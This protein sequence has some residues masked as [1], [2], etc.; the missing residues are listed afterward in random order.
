MATDVLALPVRVSRMGE[1]NENDERFI[2]ERD[3]IDRGTQ[4]AE[5]AGYVVRVYDDK[6]VSGATPFDQRPGMGEALRDL[7]AGRIAG[8]VTAYRDRLVRQDPE[9]NVT[10]AA[11]QRRIRDADGVLIVGDTPAA[12]IGPD[13]DV[14]EGFAG[15]GLD[16]LVALDGRYREEARKR[17]DT[18]NRYAVERGVQPGRTPKWMRRDEDGYLHPNEHT[19]AVVEAV[20]ARAG[21][22]SWAE[23]AELLN[24]RG[25]PTSKGGPW[26]YKTAS[27][28]L[29]S[30]LLVGRVHWGPHRNDA[31]FEPLVDE[32]TW[33]LANRRAD[34]VPRTRAPGLATGIARCAECGKPMIQDSSKRRDGGRTATYRCR[35]GVCDRP[36]T[37]TH[38]LLEPYLWD[39]AWAESDR[40][41]QAEIREGATTAEDGGP[42]PDELRV[43]LRVAEEEIAA[44]LLNVRPT[45]PGYAD[46]LRN[47]EDEMEAARER[48]AES[49]APRE[50]TFREVVEEGYRNL[51]DPAWRRALVLSVVSEVRVTKG[52]APV[53]EKVDIVFRE[54]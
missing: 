39:A 12:C 28:V 37:I 13:T 14:V 48:L 40:R 52:R 21:G 22:A 50:R 27:R 8:I 30:E 46:G 31:A 26:T 45:T 25:V 3:Q 51:D 29:G 53:A 2:A 16:V 17:W 19:P 49:A 1:R 5:K 23:V 33:L 42:S 11:L 34:P 44:Y 32:A 9:N 20:R 36:A 6:D 4:L 18:A 15:L 38:N 24:V 7:E 41:A 43:A 10:L 35:S 47:L 54:A